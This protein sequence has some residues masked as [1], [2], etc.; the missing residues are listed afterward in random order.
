MLALDVSSE[1]IAR[2][3]ATQ[4]D[5]K[6]VEFRVGN[7]MDYNLREEEPWDLIVMSET[8]YFLGWLYSFFDVSWV[9]AEMF[10]ATRPGGQMLLANTQFETGEPLLRPCII[11]TYRDLF[12]NV[13]YELNAEKILPGV[14]H[15]VALEVLM[16]L[17]RKTDPTPGA[18]S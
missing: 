15:G 2:A 10:E 1:A 17:Y 18:I 12:L 8:V 3:R 6:Q 9:A 13:G 14:K 16:T 7:I 11:R 5:L 4:S